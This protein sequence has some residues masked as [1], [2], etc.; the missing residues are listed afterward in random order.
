MKIS[1]LPKRFI[2]IV[3]F[4]SNVSYSFFH[5]DLVHV[6]GGDLTGT[7]SKVVKFASK[8]V[9]ECGLCS[10]K[11]FICEIC[12]NPKVIYPFEMDATDQVRTFDTCHNINHA[13]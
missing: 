6:A 5:Q 4:P 1:T 10:Q 11:G 9:Y 3:W 7:I 12:D 13:I 8:H 2:G